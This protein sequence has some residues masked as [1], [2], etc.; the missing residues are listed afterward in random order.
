[1]ESER[2]K[3]G[4]TAWAAVVQNFTKDRHQNKQTDE[5]EGNTTGRKAQQTDSGTNR[6]T[7]EVADNTN[8]ADGGTDGPMQ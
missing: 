4:G 6:R 8:R 7:D 2:T 1:M 3:D 5:L